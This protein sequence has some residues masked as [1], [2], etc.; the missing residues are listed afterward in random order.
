M[1][2]FDFKAWVKQSL[3]QEHGSWAFVVEPLLI[4]SFAGGSRAGIA[5]L[6]F[7]LAFLGY[8]PGVIGIKDILRK[9]SYPRTIPSLIAGL[10][11][12]GI[13]LAMMAL[14]QNWILIG[15][16]AVLGGLFV[17]LDSRAEKRSVLR[18]AVGAMLAI[19][20]ACLVAPAASGVFVTR[21]LG[22]LLSVRGFIARY[23]DATTCRW[24]AVGFAVALV[25]LSYFAFGPS[26]RLAAYSACAARVIFLALIAGKEV[27]PMRIG[28]V[29][30]I[31]G[32]G[33]LVA[34]LL[35]H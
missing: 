21:A 16:L 31:F 5:A 20:A 4:S 30:A 3:P 1:A 23:D 34:W 10:V 28:M 19:P 15:S 24:L 33:V 7:F 14:V 2:Q 22:A 25:G 8:R 12:C 17:Y 13:G 18:E 11:L 27:K 6:G 26:L 35:E 9:K 32:T 29:E